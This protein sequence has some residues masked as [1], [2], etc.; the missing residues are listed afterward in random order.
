MKASELIIHLQGLIEKHGDQQVLVREDGC[1]GY[2]M[3]TTWCSDN[4]N[5]IYVEDLGE[6][7]EPSNEM[8]KEL[9]PNI[10]LE[11]KDFYDWLETYQGDEKCLYFTIGCNSLIYST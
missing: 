6:N 4:V 11:G 8:I 2:G 5:S 9:F 10:N 7:D 3:H 1:G